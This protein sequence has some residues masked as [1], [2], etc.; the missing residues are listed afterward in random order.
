MIIPPH[1]DM[2]GERAECNVQC[3]CPRANCS[4]PEH[5]GERRLVALPQSAI[6]ISQEWLTT[7]ARWTVI[8]KAEG[9][10]YYIILSQVDVYT[11]KCRGR[12][13]TLAMKNGLPCLS[14]DLF[15]E[16]MEDIAS[17]TTLVTGHPWS[18]VK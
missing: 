8:A 13:K 16:A 14:K 5:R 11:S 18:E 12:P 3:H 9:T 1:P 15:W 7:F 2:S 6:L 4:G 10:S 17:Q